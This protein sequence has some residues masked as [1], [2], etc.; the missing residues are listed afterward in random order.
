M[1]IFVAS[2]GSGDCGDLVARTLLAQFANSKQEVV[3]ESYLHTVE[4]VQQ[5]ID[6]VAAARGTLIHTMVDSQLRQQLI[7]RAQARN[8]PI[9]DLFGPL[10]DHL[11]QTLQQEPAGKPGLYRQL[12]HSYFQL[13]EAIEYTVAHDDGTRAYE[14]SLADIVLLG[15]SRVGKTPLSVY[16][17]MLGWKVAN[18][19]LAPG[20]EPPKELFQI[21]RRRI[22]GLTIA[23]AQLL[24]HRRWRQQTLGIA[25]GSYLDLDVAREEIRSAN[26]FYATHNFAV[27]DVSDKPI[28]T[29]GEEVITK[30]T[31]Q[32]A[33]A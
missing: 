14:L 8:I 1:T 31:Q 3:I 4:E 13:I 5:M 7:D 30:V 9:F 16:L 19:A 22:V 20:V 10:L 32:L 17:S 24:V 25:S 6:R 11:S 23:P 18:V 26:H 15:A 12:N 29:S 2:G 28:E 27:I 33:K 21:D